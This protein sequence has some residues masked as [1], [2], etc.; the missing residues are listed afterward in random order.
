MTREEIMKCFKAF[1]IY[2][3]TAE[4]MSEGRDN[5]TVVTA[6]LEAGMRFIQYREK[7]KNGLDR[8]E[9]CLRLRELTKAY[10]AALIIDDFVDLAIAVKAD[11][12]HIGQEDLPASVVRNLVGDDMVI[13][14]STH[15]PQ[16]L[17]Q[18]NALADIVDYVGV[19]PVFAT[20]TKATAVPVGFEYVNYALGNSRL[21]FV[22]IGGI[23]EDNI[24]QIGALGVENVAVVSDITRAGDIQTK[25]KNLI[26]MLAKNG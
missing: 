26:K 3:I 20:Q 23:N 2:G 24:S 21:P 7:T 14:L 13:G 5:I 15:S 10:G 9:E 25:I 16:Q 6:M 4:A 8:Y 17:E 11:G 18:A 1:P 19:G 12:V 22:A